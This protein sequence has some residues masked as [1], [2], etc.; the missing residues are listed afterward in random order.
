MWSVGAVFHEVLT[1]ERLVRDVNNETAGLWPTMKWY[2]A[3]TRYEV[4]ADVCNNLL[5]RDARARPSAKDF[6]KSIV[7]VLPKSHV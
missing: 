3:R 4:D 5:N 6:L 2:N 7:P 1:G